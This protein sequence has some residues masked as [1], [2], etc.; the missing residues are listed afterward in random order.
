MGPCISDFVAML[1][2]RWKPAGSITSNLCHLGSK[3]IATIEKYMPL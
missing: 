2:V 3:Y 1:S